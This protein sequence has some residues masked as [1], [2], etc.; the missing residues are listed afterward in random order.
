[1]YTL[2]VYFDRDFDN[3]VI[4]SKDHRA[5]SRTEAPTAQ[6]HIGPLRDDGYTCAD[7]GF[8]GMG[9]RYRCEAGCKFHVHECCMPF[10]VPPS[11][12]SLS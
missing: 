2:Q 10:S 4:F 3:H 12:R 11:S 1:M 8:V 6:R 5:H 9:L 7:C